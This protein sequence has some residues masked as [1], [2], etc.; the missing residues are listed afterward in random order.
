MKTF[1]KE[2]YWLRY[3]EEENLIKDKELSLYYIVAETLTHN[4][5]KEDVERL[6]SCSKKPTIIQQYYEN[7]DNKRY[8]Q[9]KADGYVW[10][11]DFKKMTS[12]DYYGRLHELRNNE[13][14]Q[15]YVESGIVCGYLG[16]ENRKLIYDEVIEELIKKETNDIKEK[17][18]DWMCSSFA[19]HWMDNINR[20]TKEEFKKIFD[21][22]ILSEMK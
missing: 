22:E 6:F 21:K 10:C 19:R 11:K 17:V 18:A 7:L 3:N 8:A 16:H 13:H 2:N 9:R 1:L 14:L 4:S 5:H 15:K 12:E 20:L